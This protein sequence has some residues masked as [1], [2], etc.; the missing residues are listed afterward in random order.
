MASRLVRRLGVLVVLAAMVMLHA[1]RVQAQDTADVVGTVTDTSGAVIPGATITLTNIG[2][3]IQQTTQSNGTGDY[4]FNLLQVGTYSIKVEAK[5]FKTFV[6]PNITLAAGDRA[7]ADAK[8][9]LGD[10]SQTVEVSG[11]VA[12]ALQT[13]TSTIGTLV[14]SQAVE[15]LPLDGRNIVKLVQLSA[16]TTEGA[17]GSIAAGNR[18]DDR[19]QTS[20]FSANGQGDSENESMIDGFDNNER[21]IGTIGARPSIDAI[22]E[23]NVSINKY[24]A[25]VGRTGG[26]VVDIITKSGTNSF[27]GSAFE[28]F[29]NKVLNTNPNWN[30][31]LA[32]NPPGAASPYNSC[33]TAAACPAAPN[34]AF[35]QNQFGGSVGGPIIKDKTFFFVDYEGFRYATGL[36]ASLYSVPTAC[37]KGEA[38]C[39][40]GNTQYGDFS[41]YPSVGEPGVAGS[42]PCSTTAG[43]SSPLLYGSTTCPYVVIPSSAMTPIGKAFFNMY[44][45]PNTGTAGA[46]T[47]NYVVNPVKTYTSKT[48]DGRIDQHFNQNNTL[49]GRITYNQETTI[50][51][52]GFPDVYIDPTTGN[53]DTAGASG[54]VK[55][56]PVVTSYA[57]PNNEDQYSFGTSYVHVYNANTVLNLKFGIF[58][59][60]IL[61]FPANQGTDISTKLGFPCTATSCVNFAPA[62]SLVG[63]SGL[64]RMTVS[65]LNSAGA[66][67]T[68]GDTT[69]V[70]LGYF[71]TAFQYEAQLT[72]NKGSHSVRF[73]LGLVRRRSG[74]GQSNNA[75]GGFSF[76][77]SFTGE[78][79]GD[80]LEGLASSQTRNNALVQEG[81]R[82]WEPHGYVQ[83][84]WRIKPW[85]TLNL[86][87]R[88]DIF[89]AYTEVHGRISNYD[90]YTGL[91]V[92]PA[93]PGTQ[94]SNST[95]MVTTPYTDLAPRFGFA[96]TLAHNTV[97]R[98]GFGLT[99]FPTNY[100][101]DY[102]FQNAPFNYSESC[103]LENVGTG[104]PTSPA[105]TTTLC[106]GQFL[107]PNTAVYSTTGSSQSLG[108]SGGSLVAGGL[109]IPVLNVA[110]ATNTAN[111][112]ST[113][114]YAVPINQQEAYLEQFNLQVQKQF[115]AN[116]L[117]VGYV[118]E[119]GRH[120]E[121]N[122]LSE[123][124]PT[125]PSVI[126]PATGLPVNPAVATAQPLTQGGNTPLGVLQGYPYMQT[127]GMTVANN[128]GTSAY[129]GLQTSFVRRFSQGLTV[130]VNY[131]WS[132]MMSNITNTNA[133]VSSYFAT[134]T[135]CFVD[136]TNGEYSA[137]ADKT[138]ADEILAEAA[139]KKE[140]GFQ[141]YN[142]GNDPLDVEH[143]ITWGLNYDIPYGNSLT[144]V[145]GA[146]LKGWSLNTSG[147]WQT[148]LPFSVTAASNTSLLGPTQ[149]L[150]QIG[151]GKLSNPTLRDWFNLNDFVQP[152]WGTLGN[153]RYDQLYGPHQKRFDF[154]IFKTFP[155]RENV[156]LE[157]RTE[158]F[159]L[160]NQTNL[161]TP[162]SSISF[163]GSA[164]NL[165]GTHVTTGEITAM[166]GNWNQREIQFGLKLLF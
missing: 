151:S 109:P 49:F 155:I 101:S 135:P 50:T 37:E 36:S 78:A 124:Q 144:G 106:A 82:T 158:V 55:V 108:Y 127:V 79:A 77:G 133:C 86:G 114:M 72:W 68:I 117:S 39:P 20:A 43:A 164:V 26:A 93:L 24:D 6:A 57:G 9:E 129:E 16:G 38:V 19:R 103:G 25:S 149:Y 122:G 92:S 84:D 94:Q 5:G 134:M 8:L 44:P 27:H 104:T 126:N 119:L 70:P 116:V 138:A 87:V 118:G 146:F 97:L 166:N 83:D 18:P 76:N 80:L 111:Y 160:F 60:K 62:S 10:I 113:T 105:S 4:I 15:D 123:N 128:W 66:F 115:G 99:F 7:R 154:S 51:P 11:T 148:G 130:N 125:E 102:Y 165:S 67:S 64:V 48:W 32:N 159:N 121:I 98:G 95:A 142:W 132:H 35:R 100:R 112:A 45:L 29:R 107:A 161:N 140:Y 96:A 12:P 61:S 33:P 163:N 13:D 52:N 91:L 141:Q 74:V 73:G 90:P 30:F 162:N 21:M 28:F 42:S 34:P 2:T 136:T 120:A 137:T 110:N 65:G 157:F 56:E 139:A 17:P 22:Q 145:E 47:N 53:L 58:R 88:Y 153:Q 54:A 71:D 147:A 23:V 131:T 143:R 89:S 31:T 46:L 81:F 69:Y 150:D 75:Q 14:T 40:D 3:N 1:E 156:K 41:D 63:S 152:S 59:S 85:L